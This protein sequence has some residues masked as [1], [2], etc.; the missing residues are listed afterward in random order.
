[1]TDILS[2]IKE[3]YPRKY[4]YLR[5]G[6]VK[7]SE[8]KV[9][10]TFLVPE[11]IYDFHLTN[12]DISAIHDAA[13]KAIGVGYDVKCYFEKVILTGESVRSAL[14]EFLS[15]NFPLVAA[16]IDYSRVSI[17]LNRAVVGF[18]MQE[19]IRDYIKSGDFEKKV[20][21]F[22]RQKYSID[23]T[24]TYDVVADGD[25][26]LSSA[27][28]LSSGRYGKSVTVTD[29][30]LLAGKMSELSDA[31][32]HI[33]TLK[34]EGE[35]VVCCGKINRLSFKTRDEAKRAEVKRFFKH[36]YYFGF[37]DS[38]GQLSALFNTDD[39][40]KAL[41]NG[42]EV[43]CKGR[44]S[45]RDDGTLCMFVKSI[46]LCKVP[47]DTIKEQTKPLDPPAAYSVISPK[48]YKNADYG[49][50]GF[51]FF[52]S[53]ETKSNVNQQSGV[54]VAM[55]T[56]DTERDTIPYEI[57]VCLIENGK[58]KEYIHTF[59]K[60]AFKE[61]TEI[62]DFANRMGY[63][64]PRLSTIIPDLLKFT[65]NKLLVGRDPAAILEI[66][67]KIA[68]PL[69]YHFSNDL[70]V[71][72]ESVLDSLGTKIENAFDEAV[73]VANAFISE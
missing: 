5:L 3:Y 18:T 50:I 68:K 56:L 61:D 30:V 32:V 70:H 65:A 63:S 71:V 42:A 7:L 16:N 59:L 28:M 9:S 12:E 73:A 35:N 40:Y 54:S 58:I 57:A 60:V 39:E 66:L 67:N 51:D 44:V 53:N 11:E 20:I 27:E 8:K 64:S 23:I 24:V 1:M 14:A 33:S 69:R 72:K 2:I 38:T 31:A 34:G 26:S 45:A 21:A 62:A 15:K 13:A 6:R 36:Y 52:E 49:Q 22:F 17:D 47:F 41:V 29:K 37:N 4:D 10:V 43:V 46:A 19:N 55:R 25:L 48:E